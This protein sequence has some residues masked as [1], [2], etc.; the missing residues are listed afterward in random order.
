MKK[1]GIAIS[2]YDKLDCVKTNVNIIRNHWKTQTDAFISVC[3]NDEKTLGK[4][5]NTIDFNF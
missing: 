5:S 2:V 4:I 3:C 1:L